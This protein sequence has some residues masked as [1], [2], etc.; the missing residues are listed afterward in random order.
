MN[1]RLAPF[2]NSGNYWMDVNHFLKVSSCPPICKLTFVQTAHKKAIML[3]CIMTDI[4]QTNTIKKN[5]A[6]CPNFFFF[7]GGGNLGNARKK[8][9]FFRIVFLR[10]NQLYGLRSHFSWIRNRQC[11]L[12]D[13]VCGNI[14][15]TPTSKELCMAWVATVVLVAFYNKFYCR[16]AS[17]WK[18][19]LTT[20]LAQ[21]LGQYQVKDNLN[22]NH[23]LCFV[24]FVQ[25]KSFIHIHQ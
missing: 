9:F 10:Y 5:G 23:A 6:S 14:F 7:G 16:D 17:S 24:L 8:T 18:Q 19:P 11:H 2:K 13:T 22:L 21:I 15:K 1:D 20:S 4:K 12:H 25:W 3:K